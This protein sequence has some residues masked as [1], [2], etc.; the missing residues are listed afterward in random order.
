M[1]NIGFIYCGNIELK[2]Y[3]NQ[4]SLIQLLIAMDEH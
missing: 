1:I 3:K 4:M 2:I